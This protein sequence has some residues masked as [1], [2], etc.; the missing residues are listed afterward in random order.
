MNYFFM[1]TG[2]FGHA[3]CGDKANF[4]EEGIVGTYLQPCYAPYIYLLI[5]VL[6]SVA[7]GWWGQAIHS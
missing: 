1:L 4:P 2:L 6:A 7:C 3:D 5:N